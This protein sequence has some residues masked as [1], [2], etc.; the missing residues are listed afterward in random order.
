ME[1]SSGL[2]LYVKTWCPWCIDAKRHLDARGYTYEELDVEHDE[3]AF[4]EMVRLSGQVYTPTL[5][6]GDELLADFG[7]PELEIFLKKHSL[8]P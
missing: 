5:V 4:E 8:L 2:K 7:A 1:L 3:A 6:A